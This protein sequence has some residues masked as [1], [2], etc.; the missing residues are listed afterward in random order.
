MSD[1]IA[2]FMANR[3]SIIIR[4]QKDEEGNYTGDYE[5]VDRETGNMIKNISHCNIDIHPG[6]PATAELEILM[7]ELNLE[8]DNPCFYIPIPL[9]KI[10]AIRAELEK[11]CDAEQ[12]P[13][14][15]AFYNDFNSMISKPKEG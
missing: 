14:L 7:P 5:A 2:T 11:I 6:K 12:Y 9:Q 4:N 10:E 8:I 3:S 1:K 13:M 15:T